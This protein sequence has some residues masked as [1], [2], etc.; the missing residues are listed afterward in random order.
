MEIFGLRNKI[1]NSKY[2]VKFNESLV[3]L[4]EILKCQRLSSDKSGLGFKKE[5]D[6]LKEV[7]WSPRTPEAGS[8]KV[9]HA[10]AHAN[11]EVEN[12]K[13]P[14]KATPTH[15][16]S[17][18]ESRFNGYCYSCNGFGHRDMDCTFQGRK[19][20]GSQSNQIRCRACDKVGH[21]AIRSHTV[22]YG[23]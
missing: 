11:K 8:N 10:P 9:V 15:Q 16:S 2:H 6:K 14:H 17:R 12:S 7:M 18:Y 4:N 13:V 1:E 5:E 23:A 22:G 19:N 21:V 3:I 20:T